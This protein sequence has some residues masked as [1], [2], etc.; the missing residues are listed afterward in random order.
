MRG[1]IGVFL[2]AIGTLSA[3]AG[4]PMTTVT[5]SKEGVLEQQKAMDIQACTANG[6]RVA[7]PRPQLQS[8]PTCSP[9]FSCGMAQGQVAANNGL[10]MGS[11]NAAFQ[12]GFESCMYDK[13]YLQTTITN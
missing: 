11:W 1:A 3:C 8:A 4:G 9:S 5:W 13:G 10:V 6:Y 7:G 2:C 12:S